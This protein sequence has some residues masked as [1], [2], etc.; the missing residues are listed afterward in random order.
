MTRTLSHPAPPTI[1]RTGAISDAAKATIE[2]TERGPT[3]IS[4]WHRALLVHYEVA[5]DALQ[6]LVPYTLDLRGGRAYVSLVMFTLLRMRPC[7]GGKITEWLSCPFANQRFLNVRTYVKHEG[8]PGIFFLG[9][10]LSS[11]LS[12]FIGPRSFGLPCKIGKLDLRHDIERGDLRG[13][14][15]GVD[16]RTKREGT[17]RYHAAIDPTV[18]CEPCNEGS[19]A[20]FLLERYSAFTERGGVRRRFRI[21]HEPWPMTPVDV[22]ID[23]DSLLAQTGPW[24]EHAQL[25]GGHYSPGVADVWYG[26]PL[27]INGAYCGR[28][29]LPSR[30]EPS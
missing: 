21:W 28:S 12:A 18:T 26:K 15:T 30:K 8:E 1:R 17:L 27:C 4:D 2:S 29:I 20:E 25:L 9:E 14:I 23:D 24:L 5:P 11:R 10:W 7:L 6:P 22:T 19:L 13:R 3:F 16:R